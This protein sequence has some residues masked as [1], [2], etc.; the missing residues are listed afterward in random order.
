ME[1]LTPNC[2]GIIGLYAGFCTMW[3][4][5]GDSRLET[6]LDKLE[7][8][9]RAI[10]PPRLRKLPQI[11][12][13][14]DVRRVTHLFAGCNI[15]TAAERALY[16]HEA[17]RGVWRGTPPDLAAFVELMPAI[18]ASCGDTRT[19][20]LASLRERPIGA[21][22][23]YRLYAAAYAHWDKAILEILHEKW[24]NNPPTYTFIWLE[25]EKV[26]ELLRTNTE[27]APYVLDLPILATQEGVEW[28]DTLATAAAIVV[29]SD[30]SR[31][32]LVLAIPG[33]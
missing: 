23:I 21:G 8:M 28:V 1:V 10:K 6:A 13:E 3:E 11:R 20:L 22:D 9:W 14:R 32:K 26:L 7:H 31:S 12:T 30:L 4:C 2:W 27:I 15:R 18:A 29:R 17:M 24:G 16:I 25:S 19:E 5:C 33:Y